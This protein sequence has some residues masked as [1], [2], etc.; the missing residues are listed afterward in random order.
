MKISM[1]HIQMQDWFEIK[2]KNYKKIFRL[3]NCSNSTF[4]N[5]SRPC[6]EYQMKR[7]SAPCVNMI[8]K[9]DYAEDISAAQRYLTS[10]KKYLKKILKEKN[11]TSL[12]VA[13]V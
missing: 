6:I 1:D 9:P 2:L 13:S 4:S 11:A 8:S 5:R 12:R 10:E 7:C 3:R